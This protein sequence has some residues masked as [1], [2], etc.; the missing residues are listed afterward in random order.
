MPSQGSNG[1]D[2]YPNLQDALE[3]ASKGSSK[4]ATGKQLKWVE[5]FLV[6]S[7]MAEE[8]EAAKETLRRTGA[9]QGSGDTSVSAGGS[10]AEVPFRA[11]D[12]PTVGDPVQVMNWINDIW[13]AVQ[14]P[15]IGP[16][17]EKD[18]FKASYNVLA[19][20]IVAATPY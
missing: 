6:T 7:G 13:D 16:A 3:N 1:G 18:A 8:G 20:D 12:N 10:W 15:A 5:T 14:F 11:T 2:R 4:K 17:W 19:G 9:A